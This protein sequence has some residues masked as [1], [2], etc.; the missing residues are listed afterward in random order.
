MWMRDGLVGSPIPRVDFI[1]QA[2]SIGYTIQI[3]AALAAR[4][5][6]RQSRLPSPRGGQGAKS[7]AVCLV[8]GLV[9]GIP[10][11]LLLGRVYGT[12]GV[13]T[14]SAAADALSAAITLPIIQIEARKLLIKGDLQPANARG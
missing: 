10:F 1:W 8:R 9:L 5:G 2:T 6:S 11:V 7:L 12:V 13:W 14:S 3:A 4:P